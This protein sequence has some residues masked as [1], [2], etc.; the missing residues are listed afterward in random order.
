MSDVKKE[1]NKPIKDETLDKVSG[2]VIWPGREPSNPVAGTRVPHPHI[3]P[4]T[5]PTPPKPKPL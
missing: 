2:G 4:T 3:P 1:E 5:S